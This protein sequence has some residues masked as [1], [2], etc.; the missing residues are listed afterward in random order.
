MSADALRVCDLLDQFEHQVRHQPQG[1]RV[2]R[3]EDVIRVFDDAWT[4]VAWS[5]LGD[6]DADAVIAREVE[7]FAGLGPW[8]WKV[9]SH[10]QPDDLAVR[11]EAAGFVR[12][13]GE[14]LLACEITE[15]LPAVLPGG[16]ELRDVTDEV[17]V[18]AFMA[19]HAEAFGELHDAREAP[20]GWLLDAIEAGRQA[21]VVAMA[22]DLPISA[23]RVEFY[24]AA[25]FA[26]LFGGGTVP[27]WR[28]RG[29]FRAVVAR[30]AALA[31]DR[32]CRWLYV[33]AVPASRPILES[34]GFEILGT[35]T[36][37]THA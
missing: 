15:L 30:R 3:L 6:A 27:A 25:D 1:T 23:G 21:A 12:G 29:L 10:D 34:M 28:G 33:D 8:E 19:V 36:P 32:G 14:A 24:P 2:E 11:L 4:G 26:G 16:I 37:F 13:G 31:A 20:G 35:T 9:S 18:A 7:R 17:G 22:G 5:R